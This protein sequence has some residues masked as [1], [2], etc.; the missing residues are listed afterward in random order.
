MHFMF[1]S[2][3][4]RVLLVVFMFGMGGCVTGPMPVTPYFEIPPEHLSKADIDLYSRALEQLKNN[5]LDNSIDLWNRFLERSPKSFRGYNNLGMALYSND[6]LRL[7][8]DA[9]ET[10]LSLEPF[11]YIIKDLSLIHI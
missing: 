8:I 5:Q 6:K 7:S 1:S 10:A 9:F 3:L 4:L 11:D 2:P